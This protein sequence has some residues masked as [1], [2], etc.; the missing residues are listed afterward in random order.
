LYGGA[1]YADRGAGVAATY[2][3]ARGGLSG[4][5][6]CGGRIAGGQSSRESGC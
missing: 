5:P 4:G 6:T 3:C 1:G 2:K